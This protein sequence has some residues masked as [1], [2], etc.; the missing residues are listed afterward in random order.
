M[1]R[2]LTGFRNRGY[3]RFGR[4]LF[5][6]LSSSRLVAF[7]WDCDSETRPMQRSN[8]LIVNQ[9]KTPTVTA[10]VKITIPIVFHIGARFSLT[11]C[12]STEIV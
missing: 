6:G 12:S 11:N 8:V 5:D 7:P 2:I 4:L 9:N 1:L 3:T 10:L